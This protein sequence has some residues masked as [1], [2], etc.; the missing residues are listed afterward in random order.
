[1]V[2]FRD[3]P[4]GDILDKRQD[5]KRRID[6]LE[7]SRCLFYEYLIPS[8]EEII[9]NYIKNGC[10]K[11]EKRYGLKS[12]SLFSKEWTRSCKDL[13]YA[14]Q[15]DIG[16]IED[17]TKAIRSIADIFHTPLLVPKSI[18]DLWQPEEN[19]SYILPMRVLR[20]LD[21]GNLREG[22]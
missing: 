7:L 6:L 18:Y 11:I 10:P 14:F 4:M 1:M 19:H 12:N 16:Q 21:S 15:P 3:N 2:H 22:P 5:E 17:R 20:R 9:V 13:S 8:P